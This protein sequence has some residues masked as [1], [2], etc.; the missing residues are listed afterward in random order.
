MSLY[1]DTNYYINT[2]DGTIP[3]EDVEKYLEMSQEVID[4]ITFN[5]I[6]KI[7]FDNLSDIQQERVKKAI[8]CQADYIFEN[9]Y[10]GENHSDI[11]SY[12]VLDISVSIKEDSNKTT[13]SKMHLS[14]RAYNLI[15]QTGL[16]CRVI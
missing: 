16:D 11:S 14:E 9:G 4:S 2:Y 13:A 1:V 3:S 15:R 12:N 7:G 8:C 5:R 6:V 10:N